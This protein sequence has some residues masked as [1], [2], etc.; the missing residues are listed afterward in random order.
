LKSCGK[1]FMNLG[2]MVVA[3][4]AVV[5]A[6]K[7]PLKTALFPLVVGIPFF[8]M[9]TA[10]F[11]LTLSRKKRLAE[12]EAAPETHVVEKGSEALP[13]GKTAVAYLLIISLLLIILLLGFP[14]GI[15]LFV[16]LYLKVYGKEKWEISL[17]L[18]AVAYA[19]LYGLFIKILNIPFHKGWLWEGLRSVGIEI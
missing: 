1:M 18:T 2:A 8:L 11:A 13:A 12:K 10:E 19:S 9:A 5:T 4:W 6:F 16:F 3:A 17:F 7:W 15:T 14:A